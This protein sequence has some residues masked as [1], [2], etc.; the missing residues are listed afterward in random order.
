M[1]SH[2]PVR[3]QLASFNNYQLPLPQKLDRQHVPLTISVPQLPSLVSS[4]RPPL[5]R[6]NTNTRYSSISSQSSY[7]SWNKDQRRVSHYGDLPRYHGPSVPSQFAPPAPRQ[8]LASNDRRRRRELI[9]SNLDKS[10]RRR[11]KT[12]IFSNAAFVEYRRN[13]GKASKEV[14]WPDWMEDTFWDG[15]STHNAQSSTKVLTEVAYL[16]LPVFGPRDRFRLD[17]D[18]PYGRNQCIGRWLDIAFTKRFPNATA[19]ERQRYQDAR[20][21]I[22]SHLQVVKGKLKQEPEC[23]ICK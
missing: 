17:K 18:K 16:T 20:K 9:R 5:S 22:S 6:T 21:L 12:I 1:V 23:P 4:I 10:Q 8:I 15:M 2:M 14:K 7:E 3:T 13:A 11:Y 19:E